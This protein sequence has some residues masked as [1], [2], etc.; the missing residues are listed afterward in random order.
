MSVSLNLVLIV[1]T[2]ASVTACAS[3]VPTELR[4]ARGA[5]HHATLGPASRSAP[6][7]LKTAEQALERAERSF[8]NG[9]DRADTID[10]AYIAERRAQIATAIAQRKHAEADKIRYE[11]ERVDISDTMR[12]TAVTELS[13]TKKQLGRSEDKV[14][15]AEKKTAVAN[16]ETVKAKA[17]AAA[18]KAKVDQMQASL[19]RWAQLAESERGLVITLSSGVIFA[20]GKS[21]VLPAAGDKLIQVAALL[22]ASPE[23]HVTVE[24]HSD[25]A[26]GNGPNQT[27][28]QARADAVRSYLIVQGVPPQ[29]VTS[30][31]FGETQPIAT[32]A[33]VEGRA[34]NRRVE[35]VLAPLPLPRP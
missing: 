5:Y 3:S 11:K 12:V 14:D 2:S 32:N 31:G 8:R 20:T 23:R 26:G 24:G 17:D 22:R 13:T 35:I 27:L 28:S 21:D 18:S 10:L 1:L 29:T 7:D 4:S 25:N 15:A 30:R 34:N 6:A 9:D 16:A 33:T 19:A